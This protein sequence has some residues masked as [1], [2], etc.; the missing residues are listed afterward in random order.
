MKIIQVISEDL[1]FEEIEFS[2]LFTNNE[3]LHTLNRD[4]RGKDKPTDVLSFP[5]DS[6]DYLGDL[7]IS[8]DKAV[9]QAKT[10][11]CTLEEELVRLI[12]HGYLHLRG[13]DHEGVPKSE[14]Q[15]MRRLEK[16]LIKKIFN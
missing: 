14:A 2:I 12:I 5:D 11:N 4:Y 10:Y 1:E 3:E 13:Y 9:S 6:D 16:K 15:K 8:I 7:A